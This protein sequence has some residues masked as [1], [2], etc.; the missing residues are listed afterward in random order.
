[1]TLAE[2]PT[3]EL[4]D[5]IHERGQSRLAISM[6]RSRLP[7]WERFRL[8]PKVWG[9]SGSWLAF[10]PWN[11]NDVWITLPFVYFGVGKEHIE[12][13]LGHGKWLL[14]FDIRWRWE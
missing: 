1:M 12:L 8:G 11:G 4:V 14:N 9:L 3:N 5:A 13:S 2:A 10:C 6:L 7:W